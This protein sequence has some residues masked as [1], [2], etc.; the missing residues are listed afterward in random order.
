MRII[1]RAA[2]SVAL[3]LP[4]LLA[5]SASALAS[6]AHGVHVVH[7]GESIQTV[8]DKAHAGDTVLVK[9]GV[10]HE[11]LEID[12]DGITLIGQGAVLE[13]PPTPKPLHC[14][15][16]V[17]LPG[18]A[19]GLCVTGTFSPDSPTTVLRPIR[20][21][22]VR[23]MVVH[24]FPSTGIVTAGA[25]NVRI[26]DSESTGG[27]EYGILLSQ[28]TRGTLLHN[29]VTGGNEAGVY[30]GDSPDSHDVVRDNVIS[31]S[32][33]F[34]VFVRNSSQGTVADN[35]ITSNCTGVAL[36]PTVNDPTE[37]SNWLITHNRIS[38]NR[39]NCPTLEEGGPPVGGVGVLLAGSSRATVRANTITN[40]HPASV[41]PGQWSGGVVL[42]S[43]T[44]FGGPARPAD[45]LVIGNTLH[46][47]RAFD[48]N[49]IARGDRNRFVANRCGTSTPAGLCG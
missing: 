15:T 28:T 2:V 25:D 26:E 29:R 24:Q 30:L 37:V 39:K 46:A 40:N 34:G 36:L 10:Y 47:N 1:K 41:M 32:G 3:T 4:A 35:T 48:I 7:P 18:D 19:F 43:A 49:V 9:R 8:L 16:D 6:T 42:V 44:V 33:T 11:A 14:A 27:T 22:T 23:G 13:P 31:D 38:D 12:T 45:N 20:N 17:G 5:G 21:V